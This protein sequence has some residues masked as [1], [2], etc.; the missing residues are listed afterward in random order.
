MGEP[1]PRYVHV[2]PDDILRDMAKDRGPYAEV[3]DTDHDSPAAVERRELAI[4]L[5]EG[6]YLTCLNRGAHRHAS[7]EHPHGS[8]HHHHDL[9]CL[10]E[11][12]WNSRIVEVHD[13]QFKLDLV[14][15]E[16]EMLVREVNAVRAEGE[17]L[18]RTIHAMREFMERFPV[19]VFGRVWD[20]YLSDQA[21][22]TADGRR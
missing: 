14:A 20:A 4:Q 3:V 10:I 2:M 17:S 13:L 16:R 21:E 9:S 8:M 22:A 12:G 6:A 5:M 15:R 18:R 1:A 11:A 19:P 7:A